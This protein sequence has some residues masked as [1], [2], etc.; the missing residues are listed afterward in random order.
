MNLVLRLRGKVKFLEQ[1]AAARTDL[2]PP[3]RA[4]AIVP[5]AIMFRHA[6]RVGNVDY[7]QLIFVAL[8][9][10]FRKVEGS[11][12]AGELVALAGRA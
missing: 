9:I 12:L 3:T 8:R 4:G 7:R 1:K 5:A 2:S 10:G 6:T 11:P